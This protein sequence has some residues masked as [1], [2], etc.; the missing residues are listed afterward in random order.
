[1]GA[2]WKGRLVWW[3]RAGAV[4]AAA[5]LAAG[6]GGGGAARAAPRAGGV[7]GQQVRGGLPGTISTVAGGVGGPG[8]ATGVAISPCGVSYGAGHLYVEDYGPGDSVRAVSPETDRLTTVAGTNAEGPLGDGG[9]ATSASLLACS[10]VTDQSGNVIVADPGADR[11]R[12]VAARTGMF[13]GQQMQAGDIYAI[14]GN[15]T[16]GFSGDGGPAAKAELAGPASVAM[17]AAGNLVIVD[18][19]NQRVRVLAA[20]TGSFYG[21]AMKTGDIYTVAGDGVKGYLGN[22][23]PAAKAEFD[24]PGSVAVDPAGNLVIADTGNNWVRLVAVRTGT[25]YGQKMIAGNI[26]TV[27]A[28]IGSTLWDPVSAAVDPAG[29][30]VVTDSNNQRI[31][32]VAGATGTF[33][34]QHMTVGGI[35]TVAGDGHGGY[36]GDGGKAINAELLYPMDA[37]PD[38]TGNLVIADTINH[39]VRVVAVRS[40]TFYGQAMTAG[41]IYTI[42]GDGALGYSGDGGPATRARFFLYSYPNGLAVD[43]AGNLVIPD[44]NDNRVRVVAATAGTFY[45]QNMS[46]RH[47]YT[48]AGNGGAGVSGDGGPATSAQVGVPSGVAVDSAGNLLIA[49][50]PRIR[51]VAARSGSVYGQSVKAGDIYT[52]AGN[53]SIGFSG[54]GGPATKAQIDAPNVAVDTGGNLVI[55][56]AGNNRVRVVAAQTGSFYGQAMEAGNIYTV[57]GGGTSGDGGP[58]TSAALSSPVG[59]AVDHAG[60]LVIADTHAERI[61]VVA[62]RNGSFYGQAM[63]AGDIYTVAGDGTE[64]YSPSG[65][66]AIDAAF[67][68][69]IA[70]AV[71]RSGNLAIADYYNNRVR[72]VA[73]QTGTFYGRP[74]KAGHI[75]TVAGDAARGFSGDGGLGSRAELSLPA[76]VATN[77]TGEL[78]IADTM[79]NRIRMVTGG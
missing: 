61:R 49:E 10:A 37:A 56:D 7:P 45:R 42:A 23:G 11:V 51:L 55:A 68:G 30:L 26:Y 78:F 16:T 77:D 24:N 4:C 19:G 28:W 14:A 76:G 46:A 13:Y 21:Q 22:G 6:G 54:D 5:A 67:D 57:A 71:D 53:G 50:G 17:D 2:A 60:N 65:G 52:V 25:F 31:Q 38:G 44:G 18:F 79:Y 12:V 69:P 32:I 66:L 40:G 20:R 72:V 34:G 9:P 48:V 58:A 33:Y 63:I 1:M 8:V 75:Y 29:N 3:R 73:V 43:G 27:A 70:V 41:D 64:G 47:V 36:N 74:M 35:Y 59:V 62:V 15:G 39:R